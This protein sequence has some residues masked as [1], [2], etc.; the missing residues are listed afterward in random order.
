V[1]RNLGKH[2]DRR[3]LRSR[4][5]RQ[6]L[7]VR[8]SKPSIQNLATNL[9]SMACFPISFDPAFA[10]YFEGRREGHI[11]PR[12]LVRAQTKLAEEAGVATFTPTAYPY[13]GFTD[14]PRIAV[15]TGGNFVAAKCSDELGCLGAVL[16]TEGRLGEADFGTRLAPVFR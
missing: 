15:L 6:R 16:M 13:A 7:Y 8:R 10:G 1:H 11:N 5:N 9:S 4:S 12:A 2:R 14:S 3:S